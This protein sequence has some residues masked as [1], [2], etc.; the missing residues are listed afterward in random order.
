MRAL[1]FAAVVSLSLATLPFVTAAAHTVTASNFAWTPS[2]LTIAVGDTVTFTNSGGTHNWVSDSGLGSCSLPCTKT[3]PTSGTSRYH[4][5]VHPSMTGTIQVGTPPTIAIASPLA[6]STVQGVFT[7]DGSA[8]HV[9]ETIAKVEVTFGALAPKLAT[10]SGTGTSVTWTTTIDSSPLVNGPQTLTAKATT[11]TGSIATTS[12]TLTVE[13]PPRQDL[14]LVGISA[15]TGI[16]SSTISVTHKNNGNVPSGTYVI[17]LEYSY[18]DVWR[19]IGKFT[20]SSIAAGT[21]HVFVTT[22]SSG[23]LLLGQFPVRAALDPDDLV[24]ETDETNNVRTG[25]AAFVSPFIPGQ[26]LRDPD[27]P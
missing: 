21:S 18:E 13:N 4:C 16:T 9:S 10:L 15:S 11:T 23:G 14:V 27:A 24:A 26:D 19:P 17:G 7:T 22:W 25:S 12:Q 2:S 20:R 8:S 5:G 6:G 1:T 3:F